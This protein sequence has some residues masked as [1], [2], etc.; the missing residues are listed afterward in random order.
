MINRVTLAGNLTRDCEVKQ[1]QSGMTIMH[2]GI[3]VNER[4]KNNQTGEW[5]E[6]P[7]YFNCVC[8]GK[9]AEG[10]AKVLHKGQK[11]ALDGK[12]H[13][14]QW[15]NE[16]GQKRSAV[17]IVVNDIEFMSQR[18]NA[19]GQQNGSYAQRNQ[20]QGNYANQ[21]QYAHQNAPQQPTGGYQQQG[22]Q[23]NQGYQG[24]Q[25]GYQQRGYQ[26]PMDVSSDDIPFSHSTLD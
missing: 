12:L 14:N 26:Q 6:R 2:F 23:Q 25:Q 24:G 7:N 13:Y 5:E 16:Q 19:Q 3:A 9:R 15:E 4:V 21:Q 1:T 10:L 22:Y 8:F 17:E 20:Q 18:N 11:I